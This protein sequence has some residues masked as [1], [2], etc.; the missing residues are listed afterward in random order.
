MLSPAELDAAQRSP[1][2]VD[3]CR[4]VMFSAKESI[5]KCLY[6]LVER[7]IDFDEATIEV[8]E[9]GRLDAGLAPTLE[10]ALP[11]ARRLRGRFA[12][13]TE[14]VM[15]VMLLTGKRTPFRQP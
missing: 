5:Y 4:T 9:D 15:T 6:P 12:H 1:L 7:Y 11:E 10:A 2:G 3:A 14:S 13:T 8:H